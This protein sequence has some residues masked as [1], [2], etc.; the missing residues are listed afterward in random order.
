MLL[1]F[2]DHYAAAAEPVGNLGARADAGSGRGYSVAPAER[3]AN[4]GEDGLVVE[5]VS[6]AAAQAGIR[7]GDVVLSA[8]GRRVHEVDELRSAVSAAH[9][10][11]ALLLQR[12]EAR[13]FVP[14]ELG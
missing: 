9:K 11:V 12:G 4:E 8:N 10:H 3:G 7:P 13:I 1:A 5:D 6:G 14:V 2:S